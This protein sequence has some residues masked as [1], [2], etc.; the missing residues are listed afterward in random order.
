MNLTIDKL[1]KN[2]PI[3]L[4]ILCGFLCLCSA[5]TVVSGVAYYR[6]SRRVVTDSLQG[7]A[8]ALCSY[9]EHKFDMSYADPV[10]RE[11]RLLTKSPQLEA[12][13]MSSK[14]EL[15]VHRAEVEKLFLSLARQRDIYRS[16]FFL[17]A[18]AREKVG[19]CENNRWRAFRSLAEGTPDDPRDRGTLELFQMLKSS[20]SRSR[21]CTNPFYDAQGRLGILVG[22]TVQDP[23]VGGFAG[24]VV[25]HC[26][27]TG[28]VQEVSQSRILGVPVIWIYGGAGQVLSRP[29][30]EEA[31][32][33]PQPYRAGERGPVGPYIQTARCGL[34]AGGESVLTVVCR[35]PSEVVARELAPIVWS[36]T[37]IFSV[38]LGG[39]V[40]SSF[41]I[42]RW[43][44]K[45]IKELTRA[46]TNVNV[47]RLDLDLDVKLTGSRDEIGVLA[48]AFQKMVADL[49]DSTTSIDNLNSEIAQRQQAQEALRRER[50]RAQG[51]LDVADVMLLALNEQGQIA[52]INRKGSHILGYPEQELLGKDWFET[53]LPSLTRSHARQA[54]GLLM[55]GEIDPVK[56]VENAVLTQAGE[57]RILAWHNTTVRDDTG[58][59]VGTL[60][61]GEDITERKRAAEALEKSE[62]Q[63]RSLFENMLN[64]FAHCQM[65]FEAGR[66]QDFLYLKVNDAF[67][68]LTGL[69]N[70]VGK[71][72]TEIVPGIRESNPELFEIYGRVALTGKPES[73][74][75]YLHTVGWLSISAHSPSKGHFV[76]VFENITERKGAEEQQAQLLQKLSEINQELKD[77]AYIVSHDLKA[78]LRAIRNLADWLCADYQ[79]KLD[80]QGRENLRLLSG[81]VDRMHSLID[82]V[83]QYSR[84]GRTEQRTVPVDLNGLVPE[85]VDG[86]G[87]PEH[88]AI[89]VESDLPTVEADATRITQVF[90]NLLSNAIKYMDKPQGNISVGCVPGRR[91]LEVQRGR[92]R[93]GHR[94]EGLR[95]HLQALSDAD[96]S[97]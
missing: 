62:G 92:Q 24:V 3:S 38:L 41:L 72:I 95:A 69:Q 31:R 64:G 94:T 36:V 78:P 48:K 34:F 71:K 66:P 80:D 93:P 61:S 63:Y 6:Q 11:L 1:F 45:P 75:T 67:G 53:C 55:S 70:V 54:F 76:A 47:Q 15:L 84:I 86:L 12:Y 83:L 14:E 42:S 33:D 40:L 68:R 44:S 50:D 21:A 77:F 32:Q 43:V 9:V 51:Y 2:L 27:L 29:A 65:L 39:A 23:E 19:I 13:L 20:P 26:D 52:L 30:A 87:V 35:I 7:Q 56:Y 8:Q 73:F 79:D 17:D 82:G 74:E 59:I 58:G 37:V 60:S 25:Q 22:M 96:A 57:E 28:F 10:Q 90:Q 18:H 5:L 89:H 91:L 46:A 49:K 88:I 97:R 85:I 81:R 4:R 16:T